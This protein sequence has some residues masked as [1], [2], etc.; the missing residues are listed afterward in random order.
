MALHRG[1]PELASQVTVAIHP[2]W[3]RA[4]ALFSVVCLGSFIV[5]N[6]LGDLERIGETDLAS[7][8]AS[9]N[10]LTSLELF[11]PWLVVGLLIYFWQRRRNAA[12]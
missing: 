7:R 8:F 4:A 1:N 5:L 10:G 6:V 12:A 11:F 9:A 2:R 3:Q